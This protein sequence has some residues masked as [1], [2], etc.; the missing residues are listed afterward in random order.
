VP[1]NFRLQGGLSFLNLDFSP[2]S[3]NQQSSNIG[4][5]ATKKINIPAPIPAIKEFLLNGV[6]NGT[7]NK[8][9]KSV[10]IYGHIWKHESETANKMVSDFW[11]K[12]F[13][14]DSCL[15]ILKD[16]IETQNLSTALQMDLSNLATN[17]EILSRDIIQKL[18]DEKFEL[19]MY[20]EKITEFSTG[21]NFWNFYHVE[22]IEYSPA[23]GGCFY[24]HNTAI[25]SFPADK[26]KNESDAK[27][28]AREKFG[29]VFEN[30]LVDLGDGESRPAW[31]MTSCV[32]EVDG[33]VYLERF[34]FESVTTRIPQY[35]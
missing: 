31:K 8:L 10:Q 23:E 22:Q 33:V 25:A 17:L 19:E 11:F 15:W 2:M 14:A 29:L 30:D 13:N 20:A 4:N 1:K 26:F 7:S 5:D 32:A 27:D 9:P 12:H 21:K 24:F 34:P 28:Y 3:N 6:F 18:E 35:E 16:E